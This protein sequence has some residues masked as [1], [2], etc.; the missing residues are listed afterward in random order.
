MTTGKQYHCTMEATLDLVGGKWKALILWHLLGKPLRFNEICKKLPQVTAK[1]LTQQLRDLEK[2]GLISR[3]IFPMAPPKVVYELTSLGRSLYPILNAMCDWGE[4]YLR[5]MQPHP[6]V[7]C[8]T[9][10]SPQTVHTGTPFL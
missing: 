7:T 5:E 10:S 1:M 4:M 6:E 8:C 2:N 9:K 3:T